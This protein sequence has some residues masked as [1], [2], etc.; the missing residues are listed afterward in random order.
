MSSVALLNA[1]V[2]YPAPLRDLLLHLASAGLFQARWTD[3]IH[4]EWIKAVLTTRPELADKLCRTRFPMDAAIDGCLVAD[5]EQLVADLD[6]PDP[7]DRHVLAAAIKGGAGVIVTYNLRD[8][9]ADSLAPH[10]IAA[11]HP[12]TFVRQAIELDEPT[13]LAAIHRQR[14]SLRN[15][16]VTVEEHLDTLARQRLPETVAVLRQHIGQL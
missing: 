12:D 7:D 15:P 10:G 5:Y 16:P 8:F 3:R 14:S 9:P 11:Q 1:C 6:L 13:A 2:L 4:E